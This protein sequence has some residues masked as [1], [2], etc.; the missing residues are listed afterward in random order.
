MGGLVLYFVN[1][2]VLPKKK[3][4]GGGE[5]RDLVTCNWCIVMCVVCF[6]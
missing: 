6:C 4:E 2:L 1:G 3:R 5:G